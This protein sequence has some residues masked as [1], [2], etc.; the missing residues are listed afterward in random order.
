M[1]YHGNAYTVL[2]DAQGCMV[3]TRLEDGKSCFLQGDDTNELRES[4]THL[5]SITYPCG[6]FKSFEQHLDVICDAYDDVMQ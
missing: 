2:D 1:T 3:I 6:P 5:E 4:I